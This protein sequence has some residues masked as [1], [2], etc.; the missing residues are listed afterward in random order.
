MPWNAV[1]INGHCAVR[2]V[3]ACME[4]SSGLPLP[5]KVSSWN[6]CDVLPQYVIYVLSS[7]TLLSLR[8]IQVQRILGSGSSHVICYLFCFIIIIIIII[9]FIN[10]NWVITQWQWLFY[11]YANME[12]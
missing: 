9:I 1:D 4:P 5:L 12:K 7:V 8:Q 11:M 3:I 10:C 6:W 2:I